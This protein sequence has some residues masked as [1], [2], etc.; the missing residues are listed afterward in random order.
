MSLDVEPITQALQ[1]QKD[2]TFHDVHMEN[3]ENCNIRLSLCTEC[4]NVFVRMKFVCTLVCTIKLG[5]NNKFILK[6]VPPSAPLLA[7]HSPLT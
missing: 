5:L 7:M 3:P 1:I 6:E 4:V 2:N